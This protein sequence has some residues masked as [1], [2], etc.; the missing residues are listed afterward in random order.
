MIDKQNKDE[1]NKARLLNLGIPLN[2]IPNNID[3]AKAYKTLRP[4]RYLLSNKLII[5]DTWQLM[6]F[7]SPDSLKLLEPLFEIYKNA[8]DNLGNPLIHYASWSGNINALNWF[9]KH[10]PQQLLEK[11]EGIRGLG[12]YTAWSGDIKAL[13]WFNDNYPTQLVEIDEDGSHPGHY[14][15]WSGCVEAL[16]WYKEYYPEQLFVTDLNNRRPIHY[17]AWFGNA[18]ALTWFKEHYPEQLIEIDEDGSNPGHYA[19]WSGCVEALNWYKK[20]YPEQLFAADLNNKRPI[21]YAAWSGN[22]EALNWFNDNYPEQLLKGDDVGAIPCHYAAWSGCAEAL[23]W[24]KNNYSKLLL[25]N[26]KDG[27]DITHYAAYSAST[28]Q[29]EIAMSFSQHPN[30]FTFIKNNEEAMLDDTITI[31][32]SVL[33]KNYSITKIDNLELIPVEKKE[34]FEFFLNRNRDIKNAK[35]SFIPFTQLVSSPFLL[36]EEMTKLLLKHLLP[37]DTDVK[38]VY[39][40]LLPSE[41]V[42]FIL[43]DTLRTSIALGEDIKAFNRLINKVE[44][45]QEPNKEELLKQINL[46]VKEFETCQTNQFFKATIP[47]SQLKCISVVKEILNKEK[48][49]KNSLN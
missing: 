19:A 32:L 35:M 11:K 20:H 14:A 23:Y 6:L 13:T 18:E 4:A 3:Y 7:C 26:D 21:D 45:I 33:K 42:I 15:A 22:A 47:A 29:L 49:Y 38:Q 30:Q 34:L 10:Y 39:N 43:K 8:K 48:Q 36:P 17:A 16:N 41:R 27:K 1:N 12:H 31:L 44:K 2:I 24:F 37:S 28:Q 25:K 40:S 46:W 9:K 5:K